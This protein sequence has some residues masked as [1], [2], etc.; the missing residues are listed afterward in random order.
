MFL[1]VIISLIALFVFRRQKK[2][3]LWLWSAI[4]VSMF[5]KF[6]VSLFFYIFGFL[7]LMPLFI[8]RI[9]MLLMRL[10]QKGDF[11]SQYSNFNHHQRYNNHSS[12]ARE[13]NTSNNSMT[14]D[15]AREILGVT[16]NSSNSEIKKAYYSLMRKNHP[17]QGGSKYLATKINQAKELLLDH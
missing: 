2:M 13:N 15:E 11:F 8:N 17:D 12:S 14:K 3:R 5:L 4:A 16:I 1:I 7:I 10:N 9:F 6:G